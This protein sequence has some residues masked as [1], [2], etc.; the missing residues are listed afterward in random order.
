MKAYAY[1]FYLVTSGGNILVCKK[2]FIDTFQI[3]TGRIERIL[4]A[5]ENIS[6]DMHGKIDGSCRRISELVTN[7]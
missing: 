1:K 4:K 2:F 6:K 3:S 7:T 5:H